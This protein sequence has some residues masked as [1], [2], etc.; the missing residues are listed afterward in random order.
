MSNAHFASSKKN[1][2][3]EEVSR[4]ISSINLELF[5]GAFTIEPAWEGQGWAFSHLSLPGER[6]WELWL[7]D[8]K[9]KVG[10]KGPLFR[11]SWAVW[12][13][14]RF[15][16]EMARVWGGRLG[17]EGWNG[18]NAPESWS[19]AHFLK[20]VYPERTL[21]EE[22]VAMPENLRLSPATVAPTEPTP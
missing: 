6:L 1:L 21:Q 14:Y 16:N 22:L 19:F 13:F 12:A 3:P 17:D 9:R 2:T 10:G 4:V 8:T 5:G 11:R 15:L 7:S 20:E 18:T